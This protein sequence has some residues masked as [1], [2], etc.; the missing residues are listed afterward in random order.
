[1]ALRQITRQAQNRANSVASPFNQPLL[2]LKS[3]LYVYQEKFR[4]TPGTKSPANSRL[5][6]TLPS[7][8]VKVKQYNYNDVSRMIF[9]G[10]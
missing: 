2:L 4:T 3:Q 9:D 10:L 1:M 5:L 6:R 8:S 7:H